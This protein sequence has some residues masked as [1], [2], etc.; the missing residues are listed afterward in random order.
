MSATGDGSGGPGGFSVSVDK[1]INWERDD[2]AASEDEDFGTTPGADLEV[3]T[4]DWRGRMGYV[5]F[6]SWTADPPDDIPSI[7]IRSFWISENLASGSAEDITSKTDWELRCNHSNGHLYIRRNDTVTNPDDEDR[8]RVF[9]FAGPS[10]SSADQ[11]V[12]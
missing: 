11:T 4:A 10:K 7:S 3:S 2:V 5:L 9:A 6:W 1:W 12:S 8:I